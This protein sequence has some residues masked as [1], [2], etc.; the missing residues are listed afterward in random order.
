MREAI[1]F[2]LG[3]AVEWRFIPESTPHVE[4]IQVAVERRL[5]HLFNFP[6]G[7][8][9]LDAATPFHVCV[10]V[11]KPAVARWRYLTDGRLNFFRI[12]FAGTWNSSPSGGRNVRSADDVTPPLLRARIVG[13]LGH[14]ILG[15][16]GFRQS[17]I[18][19]VLHN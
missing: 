8:T 19:S 17:S 12:R 13:T 14:P 1:E 6:Y 4:E 2:H 11:P 15:N 7:T 10:C 9:K 5:R 16:V 18:K 3:N